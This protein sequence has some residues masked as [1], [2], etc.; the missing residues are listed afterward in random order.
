MET[1]KKFRKYNPAAQYF[2]WPF[3]THQKKNEIYIGNT[4]IQKKKITIQI[5]VLQSTIYKHN[6]TLAICFCVTSNW[7]A[8]ITFYFCPALLLLFRP[9]TETRLH[10]LN[11]LKSFFFL[12]LRHIPL[13]LYTFVSEAFSVC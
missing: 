3:Y 13:N 10:K 12:L 11:F 5:D 1:L 4:F 9:P 8:F 2:H 7:T 6:I